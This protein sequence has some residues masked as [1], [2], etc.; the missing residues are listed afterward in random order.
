MTI[1]FADIREF[2]KLTRSIGP[3]SIVELLNSYFAAMTAVVF[4]HDGTVSSIHRRYDLRRFGSPE[5]DPKHYE[6]ALYAAVEMQKEIS[7]VE[8][9]A[10]ERREEHLPLWDRGSLWRRRAR[11]YRR[12]ALLGLHGRG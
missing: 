2:S 8:R 4:S 1:L 10:R 5:P 12:T 7:G 6:K 3:E 11:L 9:N